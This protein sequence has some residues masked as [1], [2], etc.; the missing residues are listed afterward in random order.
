MPHT[1]AAGRPE[2]RN[3]EIWDC[4]ITVRH[5][6]YG[7][8]NTKRPAEGDTAHAT[9]T[10][11][12]NNLF[13]THIYV[14]VTRS[15]IYGLVRFVSQ[16]YLVED[17]V[18]KIHIFPG[19]QQDGMHHVVDA[20]VLL[21]NATQAGIAGP[22]IWQ[23]AAV[24]VAL[25]R[26]VNRPTCIPVWRLI[27]FL[28]LA[29][30]ACSDSLHSKKTTSNLKGTFL[31]FNYWYISTHLN[32]LNVLMTQWCSP[33]WF[34]GWLRYHSWCSALQQ[35]CWHT[36]SPGRR[37]LTSWWKPRE[38]RGTGPG[39]RKCFHCFL[40]LAHTGVLA[41]DEGGLVEQYMALLGKTRGRKC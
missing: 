18:D 40:W 35:H 38:V 3:T 4:N 16:I 6:R 14:D 19:G 12:P 30:T 22:S 33:G 8:I 25:V 28:L 26:L 1:M 27:F 5:S 20:A 39:C 41:Y 9:Q 37:W 21:F 36:S 23:R 17:L 10:T 11:Q 31:T 7:S 13:T 15:V 29:A 34:W 24:R 2:K 32:S